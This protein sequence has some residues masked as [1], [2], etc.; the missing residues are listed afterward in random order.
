[1]S[2]LQSIAKAQRK[3]WN[4]EATRRWVIE[5][6]RIDRLM[7]N[8]TE[9]ALAA[10]A[11]KPGESVLD[12]GCGTGTTILRLAD[13]VGPSG[14][15]L[16]V[17]ISEQQLGLARQRV[18]AAGVIQVQLVL[19]DA[20]THDFAPRRFDL[21]FTRFG[22]M[23]F[24]DPVAAFRNIRS[25]MKPSGRLLLAV[26]R[27]G[28]ENPW[29][30]ASVA[31][32]R[33]LV[34][35]PAPLGPEEPG[36]FSWSDPAR[37]RRI[38]DGAGF[39]D[40]V[41]TPL[42]LSFNLGAD[43]AEAAEFATFIGQGARLLH[44]QP[45]GTWQA[46][47]VAF[48]TFFKTMKVRLASACQGRCG[49]SQRK[50]ETDT[51]SRWQTTSHFRRSRRAF[52]VAVDATAPERR[53]SWAP[54]SIAKAQTRSVWRQ[55]SFPEPSGNTSAGEHFPRAIVCP[56]RPIASQDANATSIIIKGTEA[57]FLRIRF[58][59]PNQW[60]NAAGQQATDRAPRITRHHFCGTGG[61]CW[62]GYASVTATLLLSLTLS[63]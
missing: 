42:D 34:P 58:F 28:P 52:D 30:T 16:G 5:Q 33:H 24:A 13:A 55:P 41:L 31:A 6:A 45:D 60:S 4:G 35:P 10:A 61:T 48:E 27:S 7:S 39:S 8:V 22:V 51:R 25:A 50:F 1:M 37:V 12:L 21:G 38:L 20:A 40:V 19:D 46:A 53:P 14:H 54:A 29:A 47:R 9:A 26:F 49:W 56:R 44:G 43:A 59:I 11:P 57:G 17:D 3:F 2:D 23:F 62:S 15:V 18:A 36:Q 32:I 63:L